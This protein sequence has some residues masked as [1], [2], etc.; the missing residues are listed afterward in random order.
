MADYYRAEIP[1]GVLYAPISL[2]ATGTIITGVPGKRIVVLSTYVIVSTAANVN[3]QTST[4]LVSLTG[5]VA[6]ATNGGFVLPYNQGGWFA[7]AVG[8][9]LILNLSPNINVGGSIS[10][11]LV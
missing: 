5:P 7:T 10:Y 2:G 6:C 4:G 8:D 11:I 3:F 9:S 1:S